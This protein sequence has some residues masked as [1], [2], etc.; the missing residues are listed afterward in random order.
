[1]HRALIIPHSRFQ[2]ALLGSISFPLPLFSSLFEEIQP[3]RVEDIVV[4]SETSKRWKEWNGEVK[5]R[6]GGGGSSKIRLC[7]LENCFFKR[8]KV[9]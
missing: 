1:M 4:K 8:A 9:R 6:E 3:E 2:L 7:L 5:G